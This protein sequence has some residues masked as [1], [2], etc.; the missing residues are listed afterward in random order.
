MYNPTL[1]GTAVLYSPQSTFTK[2]GALTKWFTLLHAWTCT[3]KLINPNEF[4][5]AKALFTHPLQIQERML[6]TKLVRLF[7]VLF[8]EKLYPIQKPTSNRKWWTLGLGSRS[9]VCISSISSMSAACSRREVLVSLSSSTRM[10]LVYPVMDLSRLPLEICVIIIDNINAI[11]LCACN[12][13]HLCC[14]EKS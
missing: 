4:L 7:S 11:N 2:L 9:R 3:S 14:Y 8:D 12:Y 5:P 10:C 6:D 13:I 1:S